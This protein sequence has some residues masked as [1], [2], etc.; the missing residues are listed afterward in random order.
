MS[1][2]ALAPSPSLEGPQDNVACVIGGCESPTVR[3]TGYGSYIACMACKEAQTVTTGDVPH[4]YRAV[5][6]ASEDI[7]IVGV[8]SDAVNVVVVANVDA[9]RFDMVC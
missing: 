9:Q 5:A 1:T 8:E 4:A 3:R 2:H 7:K 6:R